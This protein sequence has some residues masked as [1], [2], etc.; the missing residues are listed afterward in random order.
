M[1]KKYV[2]KRIFWWLATC[3]ICAVAFFWVLAK[4]EEKSINTRVIS[5]WHIDTFEGG[6]GSRAAFLSKVASMFEKEEGETVVMVSSRT[7]DGAK[8][9]LKEGER[10]D[11]ISFG[12]YFPYLTEMEE[13]IVWCGGGYA[14]YSKDNDFSLV[15]SLNTVLSVGGRNCVEVAAALYG[16]TGEAILEDST[17]AYV[18]FLNGDYR[19]L[20]GTQRDACR[21]ASRGTSVY[22]CPIAQFSDL[23]QYILPLSN[24]NKVTCDK[25]I[26]YL[27]SEKCQKLLSSIGMFSPLFKIYS[28]GEEAFYAMERVHSLYSVSPFMDDAAAIAMSQAAKNAMLGGDKEVLKNFLKVT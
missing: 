23:Q 15:S 7:I 1:S 25:F 28:S 3:V 18:K 8:E 21:F 10:P 2:I 22:S 9:M 19:Y 14:I 20:L 4:D 12:S 13:P 16:I 17:T 6:K 5:L 24:E 26:K 27:L 11:L